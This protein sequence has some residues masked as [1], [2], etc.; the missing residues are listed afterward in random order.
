MSFDFHIKYNTGLICLSTLI[1]CVTENFRIMR[2]SL[3]FEDYINMLTLFML[4]STHII[5][6]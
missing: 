4:L 6:C 2:A 1:V 3:L 5:S